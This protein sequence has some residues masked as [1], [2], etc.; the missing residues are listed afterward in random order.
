MGTYFFSNGEKYEGD[1]ANN[2]FHGYGVY[3]FKDGSYLKDQLQYLIDN[4]IKDKGEYQI[5]NALE[6]MKNKGVNF[7]AGRVEEWLDCGNKEATVLTNERVLESDGNN[8]SK[9]AIIENTEIIEP[10]FIG[11]NHNRN[12]VL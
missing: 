11:D 10:C 12:S 3:Y 7:S 2:R 1:F 6:N 9:L 4:N 5:T 8:I